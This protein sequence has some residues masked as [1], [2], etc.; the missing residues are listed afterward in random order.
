MFRR[1]TIECG[2]QVLHIGRK[3]FIG[4]FGEFVVKQRLR[5]TLN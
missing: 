2:A 4:Y 1:Q 3:I 5:E